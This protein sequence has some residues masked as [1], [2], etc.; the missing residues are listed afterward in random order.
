MQFFALPLKPLASLKISFLFIFL[1]LSIL[2][3][4]CFTR[5]SSSS[6]KAG[7]CVSSLLFCSTQ[8]RVGSDPRK[9]RL[10]LNDHSPHN[11]PLSFS[12]TLKKPIIYLVVTYSINV[13]NEYTC[14][15]VMKWHAYVS[16]EHNFSSLHFAGKQ[17][18]KPK[19][20]HRIT[21]IPEKLSTD[22]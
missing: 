15:H 2:P 16:R 4:L 8:G 21:T 13:Q 10:Q 5:S 6:S 14:C 17:T 20:K 12:T 19:K 18:N 3:F 11:G 7:L 22:F 1:L 9:I